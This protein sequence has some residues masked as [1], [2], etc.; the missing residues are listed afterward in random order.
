[1]R[2]SPV[3]GY[4]PSL[5]SARTRSPYQGGFPKPPTEDGLPPETQVNDGGSYLRPHGD[6]AR[7]SMEQRAGK[8]HGEPAF[9]YGQGLPRIPRWWLSSRPRSPRHPRPSTEGKQLPDPGKPDPHSSGDRETSPHAGAVSPK[10]LGS[11]GQGAHTSV[12]RWKKK[13]GKGIEWAARGIPSGGPN[14]TSR[15]SHASYSFFFLFFFYIFIFPFP[16]FQIQI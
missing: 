12:P 2:N 9:I 3:A 1:L 10:R 4:S 7:A 11:H 16:L 5:N 15:P 14:S 6:S 13:K 8:G